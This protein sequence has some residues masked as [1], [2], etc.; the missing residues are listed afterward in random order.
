GGRRNRP[1]QHR[2]TAGRHFQR[3]IRQ[4][5]SM[6][7]KIDPPCGGSMD[8]NLRHDLAQH[9]YSRRDYL[10]TNAITF[11]HAEFHHALLQL[12]AGFMESSTHLYLTIDCA[13]TNGCQCAKMSRCD[14]YS[15]PEVYLSRAT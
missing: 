3:F 10:I 9:L 1:K 5:R 2:A 11:D 15:L 8:D 14:D 7:L 4:W 12:R 13:E 6:L